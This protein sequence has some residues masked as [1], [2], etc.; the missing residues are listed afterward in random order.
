LLLALDQQI[1]ELAADLV[2]P[3]DVGLQV[4]VVPGVTNRFIHGAIRGRAVAQQ[5]DLIADGEREAGERLFHH[6]VP[7]QKVAVS[8]LLGQFIQYGLTALGRER[9]M[10]S[11]QDGLLARRI[12]RRRDESGRGCASSQQGA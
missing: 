1:G 9:S 11:V 5:R 6:D 4:D 7:N 12:R 3:E 8:R 10:R 2:I